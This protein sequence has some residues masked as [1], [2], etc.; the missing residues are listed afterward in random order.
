MSWLDDTYDAIRKHPIT[1]ENTWL[2]G[3]SLALAA[4]LTTATKR[5]EELESKYEPK[6]PRLFEI[7]AED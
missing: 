7:L 5:I 2:V 4:E 1:S 6:A 3:I